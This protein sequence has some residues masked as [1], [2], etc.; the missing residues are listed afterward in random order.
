MKT[1]VSPSEFVFALKNVLKKDDCPIALHEPLFAGN[2][3]NYVKDC[4]DSGY[5]S[6]VGGYVDKFEKNLANYTGSKF[7]IAVVSGTAAMHLCLKLAGVGQGDEV[8]A[9][10]LTFIAT[11]NAVCHCGAVPHFIDCSAESLGVNPEKLY[12]YL[13]EIT[14]KK[15]GFCYNKLTMRPIKAVVV[16]HTF[17]HPA[18]LEPLLEVCQMFRLQ[19]IEDAAESLGSYYKNRHTGNFGTLSAMSFNGNKIVTTGGGGAILTNDEALAKSA[20]HISTT[21]KLPHRWAFVHD[22]VGYNYRMPNINAALGCAQLEQLDHFVRSKRALAGKYRLAFEN[23]HGITFFQ[24][25]AYAKSNYWLNA[26][27]LSEEN[28]LMRDEIL[29]QTNDAG[30]MT[31]PAWVLM[32]KLPPF[33][34]CPHMDLSTAESLEQRIINIPSSACLGEA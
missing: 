12:A 17:G 22:R 10:T 15:D 13:K 16:M 4:L 6:S 5:V 1:K 34:D 28:A 24:E 20:K 18:D 30:L 25:P 2:E 7:A 21:A 32:H 14:I 29:A 31:R 8:L 33:Q 19:L 9:P 26:C 11:A 3:W 23:M 27:I